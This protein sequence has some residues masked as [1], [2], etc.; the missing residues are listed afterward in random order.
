M[1][2]SGGFRVKAHASTLPLQPTGSSKGFFNACPGLGSDS[3]IG[4]PIGTNVIRL[5]FRPAVRYA[6][7][8]SGPEIVPV[9]LEGS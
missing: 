5:P 4:T 2:H 8:S 9:D 7:E 6:S 1:Q 3:Q